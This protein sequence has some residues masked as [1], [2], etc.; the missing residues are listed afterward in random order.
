MCK[1]KSTT[2]P[3]PPYHKLCMSFIKRTHAHRVSRHCVSSPLLVWAGTKECQPVHLW[4]QNISNTCTQHS[5]VRVDK[6]RAPSE[7]LH[8]DR[9]SH[10]HS[11]K[12]RV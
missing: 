1:Q 3:R 4:L 6:A 12:S 2:L 5:K 10:M 11:H 8:L 7:T 9:F